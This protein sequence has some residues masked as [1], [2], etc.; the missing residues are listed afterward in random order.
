MKRFGRSRTLFGAGSY[1][2]VLR[3]AKTA[4]FSYIFSLFSIDFFS[5]L[6][7]AFEE[8]KLFCFDLEQLV[9]FGVSARVSLVF[10]HMK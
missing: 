5:K 9:G 3:F 7:A 8:G 4:L 10:P 1:G 6:L 2:P